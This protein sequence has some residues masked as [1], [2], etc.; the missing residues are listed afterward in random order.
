M[1]N[2]GKCIVFESPA[3]NEAWSTRILIG[4]SEDAA[5]YEIIYT[6]FGDNVRA[7]IYYQDENNLSH[8]YGFKYNHTITLEHAHKLYIAFRGVEGAFKAKGIVAIT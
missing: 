5:T 2:F 6:S 3:P 7:S 8:N 1:T 4:D